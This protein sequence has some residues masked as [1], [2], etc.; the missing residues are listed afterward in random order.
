MKFVL[1]P[2]E[3]LV[4]AVLVFP[5][6]ARIAVVGLARSGRAVATLLARAGNAVYASD[7]SR[8]PE[9]DATAEAVRFFTGE[10]LLKEVPEEEY[11]NQK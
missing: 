8:T 11:E 2:G 1:G 4:E 7:V 3:N 10:A 5:R 9:L 6:F